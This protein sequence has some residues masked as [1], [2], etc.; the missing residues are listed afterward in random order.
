[1]ESLRQMCKV[2]SRVANKVNDKKLTKVLKNVPVDASLMTWCCM[3]PVRG[4]ESRL[5]E[6]DT[7]N[8]HVDYHN[9]MLTWQA[10][11][12][13]EE[14]LRM[15]SQYMTRASRIFARMVGSGDAYFLQMP[16][17]W[18]IMLCRTSP[19]QK[20]LPAQHAQSRNRSS[21][22]IEPRIKRQVISKL[23]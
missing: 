2:A 4:L 20:L 21:D 23:A 6:D 5:R 13:N 12:S 22:V 19:E 7:F 8:S 14:E 3:Y 18:D 10:T 9:T 11:V 1:M 16:D 15:V 17:A